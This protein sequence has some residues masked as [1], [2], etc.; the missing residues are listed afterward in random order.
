MDGNVRRAD[1]DADGHTAVSNTLSYLYRNADGY[2]DS[3]L[4]ALTPALSWRASVSQVGPPPG[5]VEV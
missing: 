2:A 3:R 5:R 1:P 4:L